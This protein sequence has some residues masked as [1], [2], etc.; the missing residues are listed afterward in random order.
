MSNDKKH[1]IGVVERQT[2]LSTHVIRKWEERYQA[3]DPERNSNGRRFYSTDDINRLHLLK[4]TLGTGRSIGQVVHLS[5]DV[6]KSYI[7]EDKSSTQLH[8]LKPLVEHDIKNIS[9]EFLVACKRHQEE[10]MKTILEKA[11]VEYGQHKMI[12]LIIVDILHTIGNAWYE[13]EIRIAHERLAT[14]RITSFLMNIL[15]NLIVPDSAPLILCATLHDQQ[16]TIG[17]LISAIIA[18]DTGWR[19]IYIGGDVPASEIAGAVNEMKAS[20]L[21][22]SFIYPYNN[23][24]IHSDLTLINNT[25]FK[26][27]QII[28]GGGPALQYQKQYNCEKCIYTSDFSQLRSLLKNLSSQVS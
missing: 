13:G 24:Q 10:E 19:S 27:S 7:D 2:G 6:L 14:F 9:Q 12:D 26:E 18:R 21:I 5:N 20:L 3:V 15:D 25:I 16:H 23:F 17:A 28:I 4:M 1:P 8:P 11:Y 22:L